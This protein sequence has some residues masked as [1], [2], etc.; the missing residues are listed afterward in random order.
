MK[1]VFHQ[2]T[3][4]AMAILLLAST[5]SWTVDK[6]LCM[7]RVMDISLFA[8]AENCGMEISMEA[9]NND[10]LQNSCCEDESFTIEGQDDL[11]L[12]WN[13]FDLDH[14]LFLVAFTKS[15]VDLFVPLEKLPVPNE[16]YPPPKLVQ[17]IHILD[18]VFLI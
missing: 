2:I 7:G 12:T 11:K 1:Q 14:Q 4:V 8:H 17:D 18:Q 13:D 16:H 6:H 10:D 9:M 3:S 5:V 15:Y